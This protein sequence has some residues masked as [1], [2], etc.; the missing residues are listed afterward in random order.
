[1]K[2]AK[3]RRARIAYL[4][5]TRDEAAVLLFASLRV[6]TGENQ[7]ELDGRPDENEQRG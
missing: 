5:L 6:L 4:N 1:M 7:P 2:R 3:P